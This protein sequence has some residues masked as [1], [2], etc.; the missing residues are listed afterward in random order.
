MIADIRSNKKLNPIVTEL[1]IRE[2][3]LNI[4]FVCIT[5]SFF[6][7]PKNIRLNSTYYILIKIPNERGR[8]HGYKIT[9]TAEPYSFLMIDTTLASD[10][11]R[12]RK[13]LLERI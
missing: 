4:Y 7:V 2:R 3:T 6:A 1:F 8:L 5:Q 10:N 13:N 9:C 11:S 12:F